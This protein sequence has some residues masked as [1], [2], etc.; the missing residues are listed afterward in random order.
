MRARAVCVCWGWAYHKGEPNLCFFSHF[1]PRFGKYEV[2]HTSVAY[3]QD[4]HL[5][6][7]T[8]AA[9]GPGTPSPAD[10]RLPPMRLAERTDTLN[11]QN[12]R[13]VGEYLTLSVRSSFCRA[14]RAYIGTTYNYISGHEWQRF[15][16][17]L[18]LSHYLAQLDRQLARQSK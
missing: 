12:T 17:S 4:R 8:F 18:P 10:V 11:G 7:K 6:V 2:L 16:P 1:P 13:L 9:N 15:Q 14:A 3:R 5:N